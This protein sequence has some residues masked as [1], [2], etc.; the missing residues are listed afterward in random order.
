MKELKEAILGGWLILNVVRDMVRMTREC[1]I[2]AE[3]GW[4]EPAPSSRTT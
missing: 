4:W 2:P 1:Q 3:A